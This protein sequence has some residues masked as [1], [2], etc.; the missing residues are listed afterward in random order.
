MALP[1][2]RLA[3]SGNVTHKH[4]DPGTEKAQKENCQRKSQR[5][6]ESVNGSSGFYFCFL[7]GA[8][9]CTGRTLGTFL[10]A[11]HVGR[12]TGLKPALQTVFSFLSAARS[13]SFCPNT[14]LTCS[15]SRLRGENVRYCVPVSPLRRDAD[16]FSFSQPGF[17]SG[18]AFSFT[19]APAAVEGVSFSSP[20]DS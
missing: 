13:A 11:A 16:V 7:K 3:V 12:R 1:L 17:L 20:V 5:M 9:T 2:T 18:A 14:S 19:E 15:L 8:T 10:R 4:Q 6:D